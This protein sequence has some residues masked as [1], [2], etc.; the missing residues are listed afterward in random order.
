MVR[1]SAKCVVVL[2]ERAVVASVDGVVRAGQG[3]SGGMWLTFEVVV[4]D[5]A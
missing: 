2:Y 4:S 1:T 5:N 3:E